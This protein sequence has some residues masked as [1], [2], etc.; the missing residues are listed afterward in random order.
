MAASERSNWLPYGS[1]SPAVRMRLFCFPYAGGNS[2]IFRE[3]PQL[4]PREVGVCAVELPGHGMRLRETAIDAVGPLADAAKAGILPFLDRPFALF[5]HS[6][7]AILAFEIALRLREHRLTPAHL[8]VSGRCA[9]QFPAPATSAHLLPDA[10]FVSH[11]RTLKGTPEVLLNNAE[12]MELMLPT[13]RADFKASETYAYA[14]RPPLACPLTALGGLADE[15][16]P[17]EAIT[18]WR[19][20]TSGPFE[21][22]FFEGDHFFLRGAQS[23]V[24]DSIS[25]AFAPCDG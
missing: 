14:P 17:P 18:A 3:W 23:E 22:R 11:L 15:H 5:G 16:V 7:G 12:L 1:P 24:F 10:E 6:L 9:P 13:I 2:A 4:L 8:F 20:M 21:A 25:P 19:D